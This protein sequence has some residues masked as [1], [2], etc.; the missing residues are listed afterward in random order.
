MPNNADITENQE[1]FIPEHKM[2]EARTW[3]SA[4]NFMYLLEPMSDSKNPL[5]S[6][7][8]WACSIIRYDRRI[9][10]RRV[11][12]STSIIKSKKE[13]MRYYGSESGPNADYALY[14]AYHQLRIW[15]EENAARRKSKC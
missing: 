15:S 8:K 7:V 12:K 14:Q 10:H 11:G 6:D 9:I 3:L 5:F 13:D 1:Y 2:E 4:R